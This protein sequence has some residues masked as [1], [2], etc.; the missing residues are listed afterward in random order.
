MP[1]INSAEVGAFVDLL[2]ELRDKNDIRECT[3][4][5]APDDAE[6]TGLLVA[7]YVDGAWMVTMRDEVPA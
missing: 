7:R 1:E 2:E 5:I 3:I 6:S 4:V